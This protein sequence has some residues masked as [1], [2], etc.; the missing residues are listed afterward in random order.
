MAVSGCNPR[1]TCAVP[2]RTGAQTIRAGRSRVRSA[3]GSAAEQA[4]VHSCRPAFDSCFGARSGQCFAEACAIGAT[5]AAAAVAVVPK[6]ISSTAM[7]VI[8]LT[9]IRR[10]NPG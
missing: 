7:S 4:I 10:M 6:G 5:C 2:G 1:R 9:T 3:A 8:S